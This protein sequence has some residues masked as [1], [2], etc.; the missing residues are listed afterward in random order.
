MD[1]NRNNT[2]AMDI[3]RNNT[4]A[5]D[6]NRNNTYAMDQNRNNTYAMDNNRNNTYAMDDNRNNTYTMDNN[7]NNTYAK[8]NNRNN[9]YAMDINRNNTYPNQKFI[10]VATSRIIGIHLSSVD[11]RRRPSSAHHRLSNHFRLF[12]IPEVPLS[13][14]WPS[15][16]MPEIL[17]F[18][19]VGI[20]IKAC[21][22]QL[23][24]NVFP[25]TNQYW[26]Y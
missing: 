17:C 1:G 13:R 12:P 5:M 16:K 20:P 4:Y 25:L 15:S 10:V 23:S 22:A 21:A 19:I 6:Q 2:Y 26:P 3:N 24:F 11:L 8:D 9:T 14:C 18:K 7:R